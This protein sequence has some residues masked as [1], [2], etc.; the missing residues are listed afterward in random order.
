MTPPEAG[1][2]LLGVEGF[3][4]DFRPL[5]HEMGKKCLSV[6]WRFASWNSVR[7]ANSVLSWSS[8]G[9][10]WMVEFGNRQV[11][12]FRGDVRHLVH[13]MAKKCVLVGHSETRDA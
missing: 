10:L 9:G 11:D 13:E 5:V 6:C 12:G 1:K 4:G 2:I 3:R 8:V 7:W